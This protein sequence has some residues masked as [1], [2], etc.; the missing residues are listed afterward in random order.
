M[1]SELISNL[2]TLS[3]AVDPPDDSL[4]VSLD[5]ITQDAAGFLLY[6]GP[7]SGK[8]HLLRL[9]LEETQGRIQQII[10]DGEGEFYTLREVFPYLLVATG[11]GEIPVMSRPPPFCASASSRRGS[12]PSSTCLA[13]LSKPAPLMWR[14]F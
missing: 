11:D 7:G 13:C 9:L 8:S 3:F 12:P 14:R 2:P 6:G 4:A 10:F 1:Q 5:Q